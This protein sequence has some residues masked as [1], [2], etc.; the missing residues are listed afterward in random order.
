MEELFEL[1]PVNGKRM[2]LVVERIMNGKARHIA[3]L[4]DNRKSKAIVCG[5]LCLLIE[6]GEYALII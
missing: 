5:A 4:L 2:L 6:P 3:D 1:W